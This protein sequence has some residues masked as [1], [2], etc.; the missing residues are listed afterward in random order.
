[1]INE[2]GFEIIDNFSDQKTLAHLS[3]ALQ[4]LDV[5]RQ[6]GGVRNVEKKSQ[7]VHD[8]CLSAQVLQTVKKYLSGMPQLVRAIYFNKTEKQ[9]WSVTWHQDKTVAV[10]EKFIAQGWQSWSMK[11]NVLHVQPPVDVLN[12]MVTVR[13]H[14]DP[15]DEKNGCLKLIPGSHKLGILDQESLNNC[16]AE[17]TVVPCVVKAGAALIMR[18]HIIH[19]SDKAVLPS[20]RRILHLEYSSYLLPDSVRWA[21]Q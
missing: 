11:D 1:M 20:A 12:Q 7:V 19:A 17:H 21:A 3:L 13:L 14:L 10:T 5:P 18:P 8:F 9:N 15:A 2:N 6:K 4:C 16:V